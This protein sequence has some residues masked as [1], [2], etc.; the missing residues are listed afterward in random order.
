MFSQTVHLGSS[1][2]QIPQI[3]ESWGDGN[4]SEKKKFISSALSSSWP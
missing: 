4:Q 2:N 3:I 1:M